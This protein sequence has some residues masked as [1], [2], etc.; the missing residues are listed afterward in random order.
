[1]A[2]VVISDVHALEGEKM[3]TTNTTMIVLAIVVALIIGGFLGMILSRRQRTKQLQEKFGP[4]YER[5]VNQLGDKRQAED[6]LAARL[7]HVK[8]LD[9]RPLSTEE[10]ERFT[11]EWQMTQAEFVD[12]PLAALQK[13]DRVL[14]EVMKAKGYPV[15]DFEQR[16]SD[17][18]VDY[19]ELVSDYRGLHMIAV[20]SDDEEVSTEEMRQAMIHARA[21]FENLVKKNAEVEEQ[22]EKEKI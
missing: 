11:N 15:Q 1:M 10:T 17:I 8:T 5:T 20:K 18:S 22:E 2:D 14:R 4:E 7:D 6:E 12:S 19:P 9:I 21:L 3:D 13:A 16:A